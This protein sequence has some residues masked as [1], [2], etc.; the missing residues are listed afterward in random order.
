MQPLATYSATLA[1]TSSGSPDAVQRCTISSGTRRLAASDLVVGRR[2]R[3]HL[4]DLVEQ[5]LGHAGRL[6]DVRLLTEVLGDHQAGA[7]ERGLAVAV[8][9][10]HDE[11]R[12]VDVVDRAPGLGRA[13]RQGASIASAL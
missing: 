2:P 4:A 1:T 6:H 11:L 12:A 5:L 13:A 3:E 9:A 8:D 7:V 10:A